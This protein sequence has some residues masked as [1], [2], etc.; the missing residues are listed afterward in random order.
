MQENCIFSDVKCLTILVIYTIL[1][2]YIRIHWCRYV[3][4]SYS[5]FTLMTIFGY[6]FWFVFH[7]K[8]SIDWID[9]C[10]L[11]PSKPLYFLMTVIRKFPPT[12]SLNSGTLLYLILLDFL[13]KILLE[14][15]IIYWNLYLENTW[16][17]EKCNWKCIWKYWI[18][19]VNSGWPPREYH[20]IYYSCLFSLLIIIFSIIKKL[21]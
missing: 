6:Q 4:T 1:I 19:K 5:L 12:A 7:M 13:F 21:V 10:Y 3:L 11:W 9:D 8:N 18:S 14:F 20:I 17:L 2:I 15:L 16:E